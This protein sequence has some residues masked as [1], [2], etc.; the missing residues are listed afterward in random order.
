M[1]CVTKTGAI[2]VSD[3]LSVTSPIN[4]LTK[5]WIKLRNDSTTVVS[6]SATLANTRKARTDL[7]VVHHSVAIPCE[8]FSSDF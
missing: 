5:V 8:Y 2:R 4:Q 1:S 3:L 7:S 6:L